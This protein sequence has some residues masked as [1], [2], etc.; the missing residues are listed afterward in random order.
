[1]MKVV[2]KLH[3]LLFSMILFLSSVKEKSSNSIATLGI[4][5]SRSLK[6]ASH[7][8]SNISNNNQNQKKQQQQQA[9]RTSVIETILDLPNNSG[10]EL[11]AALLKPIVDTRGARAA[12]YYDFNVAA[13]TKNKVNSNQHLLLGRY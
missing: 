2:S 9:Q 6:I 1:M 3:R 4:L 7:V 11:L 10:R 8:E 12:V 5:F 13:M